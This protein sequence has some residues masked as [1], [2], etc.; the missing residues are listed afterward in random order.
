MNMRK[1][2]VNL[3]VFF[4]SLF[5]ILI[6]LEFGSWFFLP[7]PK[8]QGLPMFKPLADSAIGYKYKPNQWGYTLSEKARINQWGF[9][10]RDWTVEKTANKIRIAILGDSYIFGQ[11]LR[12]N[13]TI[14]AQLERLLEEQYKEYDFEVMNFGLPGYDIGHEIQVLKHEA[15][16]FHPDIVIMGFFFNDL[17]YIKDYAF[18]PEM[19]GQKTPLMS[20]VKLLFHYSRL[21]MFVWDRMSPILFGPSEVNTALQRYLDGSE[22]APGGGLKDGW[23]FSLEQLDEY[24]RQSVEKH[25]EPVFTVIPT[26][27]EIESRKM[28]GYEKFLKEQAAGRGIKAFLLPSLTE[29]Q[30]GSSKEYLIPYDFHL[31][32]FGALKAAEEM[33]KGM[34]P[35]V[36]EKINGSAA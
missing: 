21:M 27:Q 35:L 16:K 11:G 10:G 34:A 23:R 18:Y 5:F 1:L 9:R 26:P 29:N 36:E 24:K 25:F 15:V 8:P 3:G 31:S 6:A 20:Y 2:L 33:L 12:E 4:G 22:Q 7:A 30:T 32:V 13:E 19:F 17:F 14:P 28:G